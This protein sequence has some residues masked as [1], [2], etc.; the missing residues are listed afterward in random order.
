MNSYLCMSGIGQRKSVIHDE[1]K[2]VWLLDRTADSIFVVLVKR[3]ENSG[4]TQTLYVAL[5]D[6]Y[7]FRLCVVV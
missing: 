3:S 2:S 4:I 1:E 7:I 5:I 6:C